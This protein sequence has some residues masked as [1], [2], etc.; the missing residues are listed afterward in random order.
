MPA[1]ITLEDIYKDARS[2]TLHGSFE[3]VAAVTEAQLAE[4]LD[5]GDLLGCFGRH[6]D[7]WRILRGPGVG[8]NGPL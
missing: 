6:V 2:I 3:P 4:M 7:P 1:K 5:N 8:E